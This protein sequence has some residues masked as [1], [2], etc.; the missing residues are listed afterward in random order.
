[1]TNL[2]N[3]HLGITQFRWDQQF[4]KDLGVN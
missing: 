2:M 1:V 4:V 3:E